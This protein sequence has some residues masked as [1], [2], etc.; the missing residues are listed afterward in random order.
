M[1]NPSHSL[2][3]AYFHP[4]L[5]EWQSSLAIKDTNLILPIF[6]TN[7]EGEKTEI[8]SM[9]GNYRYGFDVVA[10]ELQPLIHE[11]G[12]S[13]RS[14]ILF[15]VLDDELKDEDGSASYNV[16]PVPKALKSLRE[17]YGDKLLLCVDIC[18]CAYTTH[19]HCCVFTPE[20]EINLPETH[21][22]LSKMSVVY[23]EAGADVIAPSDMMDN[24]IGPIREG[25]NAAG[26]KRA[27]MSYSSKFKSNCYGPFRD[28]AASAPSFGDRAAY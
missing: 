8:S 11:S 17:K 21:K 26:L 5:R 12:P 15:G 27:I 1:Q 3:S 25:L 2:H 6:V 24:R 10:D 9:P 19:G 7:K 16:S 28:A 13:L 14:I 23:A 18:L 22:Q 4:T 20:G